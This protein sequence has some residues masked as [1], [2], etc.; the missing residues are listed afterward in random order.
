MF[1]G[2]IKSVINPGVH[3]TYFIWIYLKH[4]FFIKILRIPHAHSTTSG[5]QMQHKWLDFSSFVCGLRDVCV[6]HCNSGIVQSSGEIPKI[7]LD[8]CAACFYMDCFVAVLTKSLDQPKKVLTSVLK[9][10][11]IC[12][13]CG[14]VD[15][16][17][18]VRCLK[19]IVN[20]S[21]STV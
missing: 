18:F 20:V 12:K 9:C 16:K 19:K 6:E 15:A 17:W 14:K 4:I 2:R 10:Y 7:G 1:I 5:K 11:I 21:F 8:V 13:F 3:I